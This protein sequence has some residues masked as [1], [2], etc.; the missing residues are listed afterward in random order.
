[1]TKKYIGI[2]IPKEKPDKDYGF[3]F[4]YYYCLETIAKAIIDNN[5]IPLPIFYENNMVDNYLDIIDG[6]LLTGDRDIDP[7][8]YGEKLIE[9][10]K[11]MGLMS[12]QRMDFQIDILNKILVKKEKKIPVIGI[13]AGLQSINVVMGGTLYQ[14]LMRDTGTKIEHRQG[15]RSFTEI[16]HYVDVVDKNSFLYKT[17]QKEHFGITTNHHQA[18]KDLA[19]GFKITAVSSEDKI[20]EAIEFCGDVPCYA[21]QWHPERC[22]TKEDI[23]ILKAFFKLC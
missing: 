23:E 16:A 6:L 18:I 15:N 20:I 5:C 19:D 14:D 9:E 2:C 13:C 10:D 21:F 8:Y 12:D 4:P 11:E 22:A 3:R 1:M 7:K 17:V